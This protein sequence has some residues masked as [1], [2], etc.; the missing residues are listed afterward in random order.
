MAIEVDLDVGMY[1]RWAHKNSGN[2]LGFFL[3]LKLGGRPSL[4]LSHNTAEC[5]F[6]ATNGEVSHRVKMSSAK[7][8][9]LG[10]PGLG[11][12]SCELVI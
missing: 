12:F 8:K 9:S 11:H 2:P 7:S 1:P 10:S 5:K 6:G 3:I 4:N